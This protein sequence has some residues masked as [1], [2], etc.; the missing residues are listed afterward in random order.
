MIMRKDSDVRRLQVPDHKF[1]SVQLS[2][3]QDEIDQI[4]NLLDDTEIY[5]LTGEKREKGQRDIWMKCHT[6]YQTHSYVCTWNGSLGGYINYKD[7]NKDEIRIQVLMVHP[8]LRLRGIARDLL[9]H[10]IYY[11]RI[12][13]ISIE[14]FGSLDRSTDSLLRSYGFMVVELNGQNNSTI[15]MKKAMFR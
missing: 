15:Y 9:Q 12:K 5:R 11:N 1:V 8:S 14:L 6:K 2:Y 10:V 4:K 7:I 3:Q 13:D